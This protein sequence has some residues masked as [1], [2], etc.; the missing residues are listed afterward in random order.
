[1]TTFFASDHHFHHKKIIELSRSQFSSI[2]E[3]NETI[4]QN[5]NNVVNDDDLVWF[6]GDVILASDDY[7]IL[8]R[9][10][11]RKKLIVG[12]HCTAQKIRNYAQYFEAIVGYSE[13][14]TCGGIIMSHIPVHPS[15]LESRFT[16]NVH[17]HVHHMTLPDYRY[18]NVSMEAINYTPIALE[19][20]K[21]QL[22]NRLTDKCI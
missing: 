20:M 12:N 19:D 15:Q 22:S 1:M 2:K 11:G 14:H 16:F 3:H 17:G 5:H 21:Q 8:S 13:L 4:I 9:L 18:F 6:L 7:D 10:K